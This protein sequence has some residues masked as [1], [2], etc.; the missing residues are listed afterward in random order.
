MKKCFFS[1]SYILLAAFFLCGCKFFEAEYESIEDYAPPVQ[2]QN[3]ELG[4]ISVS[5]IDSLQQAIL[6]IIS[7]RETDGK[8]VFDSGYAGDPTADMSKACW[9][10]RTQDALCA[11]CVDNISYELSK[12]VTYYEAKLSI[13]YSHYVNEA[14]NIEYLPYSAGIEDIIKTALESG[15]SKLVIL[16]DHSMYTAEDISGLVLEVYRN[17]PV[18][19]PAEPLPAVNMFSGSNMQR[20]YEISLFYGHTLSELSNRR[21]ELEQ[22]TPFS[23]LEISQ[24][25]DAEKAQLAFD[26]LVENCIVSKQDTK[27]TAYDALIGGEADSEGIAL[28]LV[29]LCHQLG[30]NCQIVYGQHDWQ[31]HC[32]NIVRIDDYYCHIDAGLLEKRDAESCFLKSDESFWEN[33]R[34]D[35]SSYPVCTAESPV[36]EESTVS[37]ENSAPDM[38]TEEEIIADSTEGDYSETEEA[39]MDISVDEEEQVLLPIE[40][41]EEI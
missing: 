37:E 5:D 20:L 38:E 3:D 39:E 4:K 32:W 30:L 25:S 27:N 18:S 6:T 21:E 28:A 41:D 26:F 10:V 40:I 12:I 29:E 34:W 16:V 31:E 11:Y 24:L 36:V 35:M 17:N 9:Q 1:L 22:F 15:K 13:T 19:A 2:S 33:Y 23:D 8:I 7:N 14:E